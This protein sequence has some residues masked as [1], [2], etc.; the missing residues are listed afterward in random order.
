MVKCQ[1]HFWTHYLLALLSYIIKF[2][3]ISSYLNVRNGHPRNWYF[4]LK[5]P[6]SKY[7]IKKIMMMVRISPSSSIAKY[8]DFLEN[9]WKLLPSC[10]QDVTVDYL[11]LSLFRTGNLL[12]DKRVTEQCT[13]RSI[14]DLFYSFI[15]YSMTLS[16]MQ[17]IRP[18]EK[19]DG[20]KYK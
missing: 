12:Q 14:C 6:V 2:W 10:R 17:F 11:F 16:T 3:V 1:S 4:I 18:I 19:K 20:E 9:W 13:G 15:N 8:P 5:H 7:N